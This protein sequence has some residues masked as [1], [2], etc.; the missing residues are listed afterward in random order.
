MGKCFATKDLGPAKQI[1]GMRISRDR[2]R[3]R[4]WL[5]QSDY[6]EKVLKRF[7]M[8]GCTPVSTPFA[9]HFQLSSED[10]PKSKEDRQRME[11]VPYKSAVGSLMY[12]MVCT[13]PDI[14]YAAGVVSW[15]MSNPE[16]KHREAVKWVLRYLKGTQN[17]C[18]SFG[19]D[20]VEV[21]GYVDANYA[22]CKDSRKSTTGYIFLIGG[23][24]ISWI[25]RLQRN[26]ALSTTESE[27]VALAEAAK[28]MIW[29]KR[30]LRW[31]GL[32]QSKYLI[33]C[34]SQS[35]IHL[36]KNA[37]Y[38]D[39]TK[40]ID[41]RYHFIRQALEEKT[42]DVHKV[43]TQVNFA[44]FLT[45]AVAGTKHHWTCCNIHLQ[46]ANLNTYGASQ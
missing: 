26:I 24:P 32:Q 42:F 12:A 36:A 34:D 1:L 44:D 8:D 28:E 4:L 41:V 16:P 2:S 21:V 13:R 35:A 23:T 15:F 27:Y 9:G 38:H 22:A 17:Y 33:L 37:A 43:H 30:L 7:N 29:I 20:N 19:N 3:S 10:C 14:S 18:L 6:V 5:S 11:K 25:S 46:G 31:L 45:K 40:H 39:R